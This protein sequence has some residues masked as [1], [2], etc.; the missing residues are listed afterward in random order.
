VFALTLW[1]LAL[2]LRFKKGSLRRQAVYIAT[3]LATDVV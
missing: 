2:S 1:I 3:G